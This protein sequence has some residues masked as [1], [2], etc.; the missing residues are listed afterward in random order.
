MVFLGGYFFCHPLWKDPL[1][2]RVFHIYAMPYFLV[3]LLLLFYHHR[4]LSIV[5]RGK[6]KV[7]FLTR[8]RKS[9]KPSVALSIPSLDYGLLYTRIPI[10]SFFLCSDKQL[11]K[12]FSRL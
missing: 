11:Q 7:K 4:L 6:E 2:V 3:I 12:H 9:L 5:F 8:C 1:I 10:I